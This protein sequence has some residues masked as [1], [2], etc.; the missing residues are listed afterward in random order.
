MSSYKQGRKPKMSRAKVDQLWLLESVRSREWRKRYY[1]RVEQNVIQVLIGN[2]T[3]FRR[4]LDC[5]VP[6]VK[7]VRILE[8]RER[9]SII[10]GHSNKL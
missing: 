4:L 8:D 3:K 6:T 5:Y 7:I 2:K 9:Y 1:G 10:L